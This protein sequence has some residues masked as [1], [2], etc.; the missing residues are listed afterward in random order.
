MRER[1]PFLLPP[2]VFHVVLDTALLVVAVII[3]LSKSDDVDPAS[4][5]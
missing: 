4:H 1:H 5:S 3:V 2:I